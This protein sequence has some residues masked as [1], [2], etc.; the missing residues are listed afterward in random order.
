M[1]KADG[2]WFRADGSPAEM[3]RV[4]TG[5]RGFVEPLSKER[6]DAAAGKIE[7]GFVADSAARIH[8]IYLLADALPAW[9]APGRAGVLNVLVE[10]SAP[11]SV[12]VPR[13]CV[14]M[15]GLQSV[16]FVRD[17]QDAGRFLKVEVEPGATDGEWVE[18]KGLVAGMA[19]VQDGA[20][21]L[22]L[23]FSSSG[24]Q[25]KATGHFHADGQFHEGEH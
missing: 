19:V 4:Q 16:V 20:Y 12:A 6:G 21:E 15:D 17:A 2:L 18:A 13:T 14:V 23:A 10:E 1:A 7:L 11:E 3:L 5:Q 24:G 8:P 9:A 22:K 25:K